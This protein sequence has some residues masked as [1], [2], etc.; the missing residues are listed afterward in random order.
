VRRA[1]GRRSFCTLATTSAAGRPH[2]AGVLYDVVDGQLYVNTL[3]SSRK[4]RNLDAHPQAAIC[5]PV[6]RLPIGPPSSIQFQADVEVLAV[7]H[8]DV[9]ALAAAGQLRSTT[10]HG[11]LDEPSGC[12]LR[13]TPTGRLATYGLGLSLWALLRDP[14]HAS[15]HVDLPA[16]G[17]AAGSRVAR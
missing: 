3:R 7:D 13:I 8:P 11:E 4:A 2:V 10:G 12:F 6:R 14:L 1:I 15:G 5:I 16:R 9:V 17:A